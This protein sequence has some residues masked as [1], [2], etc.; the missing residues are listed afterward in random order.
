MP[1]YSKETALYDTGAIANGL[2]AAGNTADTYITAVDQ[3]GITVHPARSN[4]STTGG[5]TNINASGMTVYVGSDDVAFYGATARIGKPNSDRVTVDSTDGITIYKGNS[6]RLQTTANGID[7]YGS[8]GTGS[9]V[10]QFGAEGATVGYADKAHTSIG[11]DY[12]RMEDASGTPII[13]VTTGNDSDG[14]ADIDITFVNTFSTAPFLV[15]SAHDIAEIVGLYEVLGG[16]TYGDL[17]E[18]PTF[19]FQGN[20][21]V[22]KIST[23]LTVGKTYTVKCRTL[24]TIFT[25]TLGTR[26][27]EADGWTYPTGDGSVVL[28]RDSIAASIASIAAG[29]HV[30]SNF[31]A[32][33][34]LGR[35]NSIDSNGDYALIVGNG[36]ADDA[37]SN[38]LAV[39]WDGTVTTARDILVTSTSNMSGIMTTASN[40]TVDVFKFCQRGNVA[41]IYLRA[42]KSTAT[43]A[44]TS[45]NV[46]T[47]VEGR[48]PPFE[49]AGAGTSGTGDAMVNELGTVMFRSSAQIAANAYF[50]VRVTY[51]VA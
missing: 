18:V 49:C 51:P 8:D 10:A 41:A 12:F 36:T 15:S 30:I 17:I 22:L 48:R 35:F 34:A 21:K 16:G 24:D 29:E 6:K 33:A 25:A 40:V 42:K 45:I 20:Y 39:S 28:G 46:G 7:V 38:A 5:R 3:N 14:L 1:T 47:I 9:V 44:N 37:R 23:V 32:Q 26:A 50:Y 43:N 13:A 11:A 4:W 2:N 19:A 31:N 27:T